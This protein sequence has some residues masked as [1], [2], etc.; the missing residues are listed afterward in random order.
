MED[1]PSRTVS[2]YQGDGGD[3]G[4]M[5]Q[6]HQRVAL[7]RLD[8]A[9]YSLETLRLGGTVSVRAHVGAAVDTLRG[10]KEVVE[11]D[12]REVEGSSSAWSAD[13]ARLQER[14]RD[15]IRTLIGTVNA[16]YYE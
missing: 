7:D 10:L 6:K 16:A 1:V 5:F 14:L 2:I 12:Y 9:R 13:V 8:A 3:M 11:V 4:N 15:D